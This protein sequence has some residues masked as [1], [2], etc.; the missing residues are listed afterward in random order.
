[1]WCCACSEGPS[2]PLTDARSND[3]PR[4]LPVLPPDPTRRIRPRIPGDPPPRRN[5]FAVAELTRTRAGA[6]ALPG[7]EPTAIAAGTDPVYLRERARRPAP[8]FAPGE[9]VHGLR[10]GPMRP[11]AHQAKQL[12]SR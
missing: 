12:V 6:A 11:G 10:A 7:E 1:M 3:P 4:S 8:S 2:S 9:E 5:R